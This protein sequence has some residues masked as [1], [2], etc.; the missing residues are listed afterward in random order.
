VAFTINVGTA[1][2]GSQPIV[3]TLPAASNG[4]AC[5]A[6]HR[7]ANTGVPVQTSTSTT[8]VTLTNYAA[9]VATAWTTSEVLQLSCHAY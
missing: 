1:C 6:G 4:W 7:N 9:G 8:S 2:S 5:F 3:L